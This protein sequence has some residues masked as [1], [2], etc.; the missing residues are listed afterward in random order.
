[1]SDKSIDVSRSLN[2][3]LWQL[4][5]NDQADR[6]G[7]RKNLDAQEFAKRDAKRLARADEIYPERS[8]LSAESLYCLAMLYQHGSST[9]HYE[10]AFELASRSAES[11]YQEA[12]PLSAA[13]EDRLLLSQGLMQKWGTQFRMETLNGPFEQQPMLS[14]EESGIT[15]A[16]R[17]DMGVK[18][19]HEQRE[20]LIQ[21]QHVQLL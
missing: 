3:E 8:I 5:E 12:R 6:L 15:D 17:R 16:M 11:G 10:R 18:D 7:N 4:F 2:V 20:W 1:M 21:T 14:D 13:A 9:V 19:R